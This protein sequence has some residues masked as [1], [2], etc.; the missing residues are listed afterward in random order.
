MVGTLEYRQTPP[1]MDV[2]IRLDWLQGQHSQVEEAIIVLSQRV[3]E[4]SD[5][6]LINTLDLIK[7][8]FATWTEH[9]DYGFSS[10]DEEYDG[11]FLALRHGNQTR[12]G[13]EAIVR[14]LS[15][16]D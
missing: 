9:V 6:R 10:L 4:K 3:T 11:C 1:I 2:V 8:R 14:Y 15:R 13:V 7:S 16:L 5:I 12:F